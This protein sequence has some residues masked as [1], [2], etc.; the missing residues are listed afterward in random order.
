LSKFD[1]ILMRQ[2]LCYCDRSCHVKCPPPKKLDL[3][4]IERGFSYGP[5]GTYVKEPISYNGRPSY[6]KGSFRLYWRP[7]S[8]SCSC[9]G[10][11]NV[12]D[13][14]EQRFVC[15]FVKTDR[16]SPALAQTPWYVWDGQDY[17]IDEGI[18]CEVI[19]PTP[20]K[21]PLHECQC[22]G[23]IPLHAGAMQC[24]M[25]RVAAALDEHQ[26]K[27]FALLQA[28]TYEGT[29]EEVEEFQSEL[30][31]A[32]ERFN[33]TNSRIRATILRRQEKEDGTTVGHCCINGL[34]LSRS[35]E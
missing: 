2:G 1:V 3:A 15:A 19:G 31:K 18:S 14:N 12:A 16:V 27:A 20:W 22:C 11:W 5:S 24:F 28:G 35:L 26:P 30:E 9:C 33:S 23:G 32:A 6:R 8:P 29:R 25:R 13:D 34:L 7:E 21:R 17:V 4:G 10:S